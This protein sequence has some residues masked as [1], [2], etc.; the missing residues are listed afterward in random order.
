MAQ[1]QHALANLNRGVSW[2]PAPSCQTQSTPVKAVVSKVIVRQAVGS[3]FESEVAISLTSGLLTYGDRQRLIAR[4][5]AFGLNRFEANL[6]IAT[7]LHRQPKHLRS[8]LEA[9]LPVTRSIGKW[10]TAALIAQGVAAA[11]ILFKIG[12]L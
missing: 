3:S 11:L 4:A 2:S 12:I 6:A 8:G 10:L 7:V 5:E 1:R 9:E